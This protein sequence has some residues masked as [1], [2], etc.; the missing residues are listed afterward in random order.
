MSA[1]EEKDDKKDAQQEEN[2]QGQQEAIPTVPDEEL[3]DTQTYQVEDAQTKEDEGDGK[4]RDEE[5]KEGKRDKAENGEGDKKEDENPKETPIPKCDGGSDKPD[6]PQ[7]DAQTPGS[8]GENTL[9][10]ATPFEEELAM[11]KEFRDYVLQAPAFTKEEYIKMNREAR[12]MTQENLCK[13]LDK[14]L[15]V[16]ELIA[17]PKGKHLKAMPSLERESEEA[18]RKIEQQLAM[19][20]DVERNEKEREKEKEKWRQ[21]AKR[22][23]QGMFSSTSRN[24]GGKE[25]S[26]SRSR[27][28][29]A[30]SKSR[31]RGRSRGIRRGN[32]EQMA[33]ICFV[34]ECEVSKF[35]KPK[36]Y[37]SKMSETTRYDTKYFLHGYIDEV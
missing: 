19:A 34:T 1:E 3:E 13:V 17:D 8:F 2:T 20:E 7:H 16:R 28:S 5:E 37:E 29:K 31:S 11:L 4:G 10:G 9:L 15:D 6:H 23:F 14:I 18:H 27:G 26:K 30:D 36:K 24:S 33:T 32:P 25:D 35:K 12:D 22:G 21:R